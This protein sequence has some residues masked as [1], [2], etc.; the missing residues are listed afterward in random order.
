MGVHWTDSKPD[1]ATRQTIREAFWDH[2][3]VRPKEALAVKTMREL[4]DLVIEVAS[5]RDERFANFPTAR[6]NK[7]NAIH[8]CL[9]N[10]VYKQYKRKPAKVKQAI[11]DAMVSS[12]LL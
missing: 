4:L 6:R 8:R 7:N 2:W 10:Y 11:Q 3:K 5:A 9:Y 12:L 1:K